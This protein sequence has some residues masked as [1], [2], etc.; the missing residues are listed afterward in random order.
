MIFPRSAYFLSITECDTDKCYGIIV[1][2]VADCLETVTSVDKC[3][4][5]ALGND[6]CEPC[7][8]VLIHEI[9]LLY[10]LDL[11]VE[12]KVC[13]YKVI[14]VNSVLRF[15]PCDSQRS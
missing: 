5:H 1:A 14:K 7:I 6:T 9:G 2:V 8:C 10:G 15:L 4:V 11:N 3:V 12:C 13:I